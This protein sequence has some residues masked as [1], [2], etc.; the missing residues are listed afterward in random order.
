MAMSGGRTYSQYYQ[1]LKEDAKK[2]HNIK[3][4]SISEKLNDPYTL[5]TEMITPQ[6]L[7]NGQY[8]VISITT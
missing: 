5:S 7:P 4:D 8:H 3:L 1:E 6:A 2:C